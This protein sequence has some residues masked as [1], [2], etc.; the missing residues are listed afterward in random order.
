MQAKVLRAA[1]IAAFVAITSMVGTT[2][3]AA[4]SDQI[5]VSPAIAKQIAA[6]QKL[7]AAGDYK[8]ALDQVH[9]AQAAPGRTTEDDYIINEF[10]AN[11][12]IKLNDIPTATTAFEAMADSDI[13]Q[14]DPQKVATLANAMIVANL[15]KNYT[16]AISYAQK[17][18]AIQPLDAQQGMVLAQAYYFSNDFPHAKEAAEKSIAA[19]KAAGT[20]PDRSVLQIVYNSQNQSGDKP[21]ALV[22]LEEMAG[23]YNNA[24]DWERLIDIALGTKGSDTDALN[25]L[26]LAVV[27]GASVDAADYNLMGDIAM[28]RAFYGD[29]QTAERH[30]GKAAGVGAKVA[31]DQK[32]LPGLLASAPKQDAKY[33]FNFAED[34]YG[35]G[36]YAEA[37]ELARRALAKGWAAADANMLIGMCLVGEG[38]YS[39]AVGVF[40]QVSGGPASQ[41]AAHLWLVYAQ[42]KGAPPAAAAPAPAH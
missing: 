38:K 33:N 17:L 29:A 6:V 42:H 24:E 2:A 22:T 3:L 35:Y 41:R 5:T 1:A 20:M 16:K 40:Q 32:E 31:K 18:Q 4:K 37:E 34:L 21:G 36:R 8:T 39:D 30:G 7:I 12:S 11:I 19:A 26:R 14:K 13:L 27:T 10:L 15:S 25:L 28:R 9:A 23:D